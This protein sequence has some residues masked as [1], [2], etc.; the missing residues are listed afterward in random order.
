MTKKYTGFNGTLNTRF[1]PIEVTQ[2]KKEITL[3]LDKKL[4]GCDYYNFRGCF[5]NS[6]DDYRI[7][8]AKN[9]D[10]GQRDLMRKLDADAQEKLKPFVRTEVEKTTLNELLTDETFKAEIIELANRRE[11]RTAIETDVATMLEEQYGPVPEA[12]LNNWYEAKQEA[13]AERYEEYADNAEARSNA[14]YK[15]SH[16]LTQHIPFGQPILVGHH[17]ERK[18][19]NTLSKSWNAMGKSVE[20]QRKADYFRERAAS[21]GNGG[22][23]SDDPDAIR[24]LQLQLFPLMEGQLL[25]KEANKQVKSKTIKPKDKSINLAKLG[26]KPSEIKGAFE[27][28]FC[29]RIGFAGYQL[30]NNS[31]NIRRIHARIAEL[32]KLADREDKEYWL[33]DEYLEVK[34]NTAENRVF[35]YFPGKPPEAERDIIKANGFRW[36]RH[37]VAWCRKLNNN[38]VWAAKSVGKQIKE[39]REVA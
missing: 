19:R 28:D 8:T 12:T 32:Q 25:M 11:H 20:K 33:I 38:A 39:L 9:D 1:G 4:G 37:E 29:G 30:S 10:N 23:S 7:W 3:I 26:F 36:N 13:R 17:S 22:I 6:S 34:E 14:A 16:E 5:S 31:A 27:P 15:R 24:K 21:V 2:T 18:H 35:L